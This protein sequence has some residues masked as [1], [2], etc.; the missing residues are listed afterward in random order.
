MPKQK[1]PQPHLIQVEEAPE[2]PAVSNYQTEQSSTVNLILKAIGVTFLFLLLFTVVSLVGVGF[3]AKKEAQLFTQA[4]GVSVPDLVTQLHS[5]WQ[6][7]P[8]VTN[9]KKVILV[10]GLDSLETRGDQL[11]LTDTM[12]LISIDTT[13]LEVRTLPLPRDLYHDGYQTKINAL[14]TYG[15]E[16]DPTNP[17]A[18]STQA[19][20]DMTGLTIHHTVVVTLDQLAS[21]IDLLDGIVVNVPEAFT[22]SEFPRPDVDV[23]TVHDPQLLY[24]TVSFEVGEQSMNGERALQY[25]RSRH[26]TGDTGTDNSRGE[27]QQ[28]VIQGIV[29]KILSK[30]VLL[31]PTRLGQLYAFYQHNFAQYIS[32]SELM[33]T[34]RVIYEQH[35]S[36][37]ELKELSPKFLGQHLSLYPD[38]PQGVIEHPPVQKNKYQNQWV[39]IVKNPEAFALE[40]QSKLG[41]AN[42]K[43]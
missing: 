41:V 11:P 8:T 30:Y 38:D 10:L 40:V 12:M 17:A 37:T 7:T 6:S 43:R 21:L 34:A 35:S 24:Q 36:E 5:G 3:W 31:N 4:A 39:Y 29:A 2:K 27:R 25:I 9:N 22:D 26:A 42:E 28:L 14:Y 32:L 23:T 33:G 1:N 18:L 19:V 15:L 16:R 20:Q 13:N